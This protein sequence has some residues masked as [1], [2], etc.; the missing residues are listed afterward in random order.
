MAVRLIVLVCGLWAAAWGQG[1]YT[2]PVPD[3]AD[4]PYI[5]HANKLVPTEA[6]QA[7]ESKQKNDTVYTVSGATSP[8]RTPVVEPIFIVKVE[9]LNIQ[10]MTLYKLEAKGGKRE[11][12]LPAKPGKNSARPLRMSL[13]QLRTGLYKLEAQEPLF[14]GEYCLSPNGSNDVFCFTVF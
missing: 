14:Q 3:R 5:R 2:G 10:Q 9:K 6:S 4:L 13:D 8:A 7:V 11:L 1:K 12:V